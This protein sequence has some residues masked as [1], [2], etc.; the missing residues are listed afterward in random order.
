MLPL[1]DDIPSRR[2]P[3]VTRLIILANVVM[4]LWELRLGPYLSDALL[5]YGIVPVRYTV[6]EIAQLF[7]WPE[8]VLPFFSSMFLHGGWTHL[9]GNLWTL[10]VFGD[11][12][13][14]RLGHWRF[15]WFYLAGGLAAGGLHVYTNATSTVPTIGASG[16]IAAVMGAYF[17]LFPHARV[18]M[19]IPPFFLGPYFVV[20]A[21]VFLGWWFILQFF[22]GTLSLLSK[23]EAAG[24]IAWWAHI[25]GFVFGA[26]LCSV[27]KVKHFYRRHYEEEDIPW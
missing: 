8:Q 3:I 6:A 25:G 24:G 7:S 1:R 17:R 21:V 18:E 4:F 19:M 27:I 26:L 9:I 11:N 14:D 13:E 23:P 16:A 15:L 10:W 2:R 5:V 20:P 12:V 22:N